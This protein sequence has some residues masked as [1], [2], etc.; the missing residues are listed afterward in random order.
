V[1]APT[2][3]NGTFNYNLVSVEDASATTC[4]QA[5]AGTATVTVNPLP[6]ATIAGTSEVCINGPDQT[7]TFT[8][9]NGTAPYIFTYTLNGGA[10]QTITSTGNTATITITPSAA[11]TFTYSLVSVEDAT[12][13]TC[14]QAQTGSAIITVN[15]LPNV[16]AGNDFTACEDESIVLTGSG[17]STY[18]W[19]NGVNN[20]VGFTPT[21]TT[22]YTVTGTDANGCV[23][24]DD[25]T[26]TISPNPVVS[27]VAD[28]TSGCA[29]L[30][31]TFTNTTPGTLDDCVWNFGNG[32]TATGCG[33]VTVT[34]TQPGLFDVSLITTNDDGCVGSATYADYIYVEAVPVAS[35]T[36]SST[37]ISVL[38]AQVQFD[39]TSTNA[40][41]YQ[42]DFGDESPVSNEESPIHT[43]PNV[44][45]GNYV[46]E[47]IATSPLGCADTAVRVIIVNEELIFYVPNTFT[48]DG[49]DYNEYFQPVFTS[50]YDPFDFN[51]YIFNR[52][53]ELIWESHDA[54]V[55]WDGTYG[56]G[57]GILVQD[58]TYTW[59]I[60]FKTSQN[61]ERMEVVG[62]V[63]VIR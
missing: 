25:V 23:N 56:V 17:A 7:I 48:P 63:N 51:L 44:E 11:G 52:W 35:F 16:F 10:P 2:T 19:D 22:T 24:S 32:S 43:F 20:G 40:T 41:N 9:A 18:V 59:K 12:A 1:N 8:G 62:H 45:P 39:N 54:S 58:G 5:Q 42:W 53:G 28:V 27:F 3:T 13:T 46:V 6:T 49:D 15:A 33:S 60:D 57:R 26:V 37:V 21:G 14:S 38:N 55:G 34:F 61:D 36:P 31:V 30:T 29:P 4:S 47:L 50:G